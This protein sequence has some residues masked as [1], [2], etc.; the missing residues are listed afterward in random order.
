[1][2]TQDRIIN[3]FSLPKS[4]PQSRSFKFNELSEDI[5]VNYLSRTTD[6]D[7]HKFN[8]DDLSKSF[9][10]SSNYDAKV[11]NKYIGN[12][13]L[14]TPIYH[15]DNITNTLV[16]PIVVS[17]NRILE[18]MKQDKSN[19][20]VIDATVMRYIHGH[21]AKL[22][23]LAVDRLFSNYK[24]MSTEMLNYIEL[25]NTFSDATIEKQLTERLSVLDEYLT[26][27]VVPPKC[28]NIKWHNR[29]GKAVNMSCTYYCP[30]TNGCPHFNQRASTNTKINNLIF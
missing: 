19:K 29:Q 15:Y 1:M 27:Q 7:K 25:T 26:K 2:T 16:Y 18:I 30:V 11:V 3:S 4:K 20:F 24:Q 13:N 14:I 21:N 10:M 9:A 23:I 5:L 12:N 22:V 6:Y 17:T 28:T 8:N